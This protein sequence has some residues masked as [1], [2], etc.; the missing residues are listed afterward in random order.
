MIE[1]KRTKG[2]TGSFFITDLGIRLG[3]DD[4]WFDLS[5]KCRLD[6]IEK[7]SDLKSAVRAGHIE[8]RTDGQVPSWLL[9]S[10]LTGVR[11]PVELLSL[12]IEELIFE[13]EQLKRDAPAIMWLIVRLGLLSAEQFGRQRVEVLS[14]LA[15]GDVLELPTSL[16]IPYNFKT[17][18]EESV[19]IVGANLS[20]QHGHKYLPNTFGY[21]IHMLEQNIPY[22]QYIN[23]IRWNWV[24]EVDPKLVLDYGSGCGFLT[25]FA[26]PHIIV[27]SY[28]IGTIWDSYRYPQTKIRHEEYDLVFFNDVLEHVDWITTGAQ[29]EDINE[30]LKHTKFVS[31]SIPI[32]DVEKYGVEAITK[33]KHYKPGEH[34]TIFTQDGLDYF[35]ESRGFKEL[36]RGTPEC[37]PRVDIVS[38]LY[39]RVS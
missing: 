19:N 9:A 10:Y 1:I 35:F 3:E 28:D 14:I 31:V 29:D 25:L 13:L 27:D 17:K 38:C 21:Y 22:A 30:I 23:D 4:M 8:I 32:Y 5:Q 11:V 6:E 39:E 12:E 36:K 16:S 26:P 2:F 18:V 20:I 33:W 24:T 7:S 15:E 37:P 34:L